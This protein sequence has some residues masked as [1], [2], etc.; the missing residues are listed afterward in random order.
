MQT[1]DPENL[2]RYAQRVIVSSSTLGA[3][4]YLLLPGHAHAQSSQACIELGAPRIEYSSGSETTLANQSISTTERTCLPIP[5]GPITGLTIG[6]STITSSGEIELYVPGQNLVPSNASVLT[7]LNVD[8]AAG[9]GDFVSR[10]A[11]ATNIN[12]KLRVNLIGTS[13]GS[14]RS[15]TFAPFNGANID[16]TEV[17]FQSDRPLGYDNLTV[18]GATGSCQKNLG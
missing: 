16:P 15:M 2:A 4:A 17:Y 13:I 1:K 11:L 7:L 8:V 5:N 14:G 12:G 3:L 18:M 10:E 6:N 9:G